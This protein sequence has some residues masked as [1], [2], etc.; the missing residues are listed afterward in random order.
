MYYVYQYVDPETNKPF[1][2]G[3]GKDNR[4]FHHLNETLDNTDNRKKFLRYNL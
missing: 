4:M 3:K 1:Y 2:I